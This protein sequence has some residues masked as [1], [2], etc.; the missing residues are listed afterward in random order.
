MASLALRMTPILSGQTPLRV[1]CVRAFVKFE[2]M[3]SEL[4]LSVNRNKCIALV[5]NEDDGD[6]WTGIVDRVV[7]G[8]LSTGVKV[9]GA[10]IGGDLFCK[11]VVAQTFEDTKQV[12]KELTLIDLPPQ[13]LMSLLLVQFV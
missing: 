8:S 11:Q 5:T 9:L 13:A 6:K 1:D 3:V 4:G 10:P 2:E 12:W 7:V